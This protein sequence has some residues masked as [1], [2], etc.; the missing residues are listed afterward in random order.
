MANRKNAT[1]RAS[2]QVDEQLARYRSM[3]DFHMTAEPSG[4]SKPAASRDVQALPFVIQKHAA[5]RLHYDFRLGWNG[6]L[7]S[8]AVTK[9]PSFF[10]GD[11]RLAVE[12]E[13]HPIEYAGF[14]GTIPKGQYGGGT[15]MVWDFG[16]WKPLVDVDKGLRDGNLKIHLAGKKLKGAWALVRMKGRNERPDKPNWLLIK[17][18][19]EFAQAEPDPLITE[20][21]EDSAITGRTMEQIAASADHVWHSGDRD[22]HR[23]EEKSA[24]AAVA[25]RPP[26]Q[27]AITNKKVKRAGEQVAQ[28]LKSAPRERFPGFI[29]PQ[30]AEQAAAPPDQNGWVHE[31]KLDG[32]RIQIHIRASK[33]NGRIVR[34]AKLFT[35]KGLHWTHRMPD[36]AQAAARLNVTDAILDGEA[37]VL[38]EH[39]VADFGEL[40]AAFQDGRDRHIIYFAFDLL[41]LDGRNLRELSLID[42]KQVLAGVFAGDRSN[43]S[44]QLS[45]HF[46]A[47]GSEV[48]AK[49]AAL[50]AEGIISKLASSSYHS[51]RGAA[52]RKAKCY[53]EQEFVIVGFTLPSTGGHGIGALLLGYYED[54][55]LRYAGRTG[56]GFTQKTSG[57]LRTRL[58]KLIEKE[59]S[60]DRIPADGRRGVSWV[61]PELVAQVAFAIWTKDNLVRQAAFKGLREDKPANEVERDRAS[62]SGRANGV[63]QSAKATTSGIRTKRVVRSQPSSAAVPLPITHPGKV[64]DEASGMTKQMLAEYYLA[65]AE[66]M[67]PHVADRPLSVVRCPEGTGRQCFFQKHIGMGMPD[68]V[69]SVSIP[70]RKTGKKEEYL[71]LNSAAGLLGL[72][73]MGVLEIHPWGSLNQS[74]ELPDRIIFDLDPD[75]AIAWRTLA[76]SAKDVRALLKKLGLDSFLKHT[77]GKGLHVVAP[78]IPEH[79][80]PVVKEFAHAIALQIEKAQPELYVTKMTKA[81]RKGRIYLDYLR[82]ERE[83]TAIAPF[84]PRARSGAPVA[85]TMHWKELETEAPPSCSV[86]NLAEWRSRLAR[87]PWKEM[88]KTKQTLTESALRAAGVR[89][90]HKP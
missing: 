10:P 9:G 4:K 13:D 33:K 46:D 45:E 1:S 21:A 23:S 16:D 32:Y 77:G 73:Q 82:N 48:F 11:K 15:V 81:I 26:A 67:L 6:V 3:R 56:T 39:G 8:W 58:N 90:E 42:R 80:W 28:I 25:E 68:G 53:L 89:A 22:Q 74:I 76:Q 20:T 78:I 61:K 14:E 55:Q 64:L 70:N 65:V 83:A 35:R 2:K 51:E 52:W 44:I 62:S 34:E 18:R 50:G 71:T 37:V 27:P 72:A 63:V 5:T 12:V 49:A 79:P 85:I 87:D 19:D 54:G 17:E 75:E 43:S 38:N 7:K 69:K 31:I 29:S 41:H 30:L 59:S 88:E 40:Q 57:D 84:S 36:I 86:A 66:R 60:L 24:P 47:K